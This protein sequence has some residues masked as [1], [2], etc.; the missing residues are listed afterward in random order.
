MRPTR[1][2]TC[3]VV[4]A[5]LLKRLLGLMDV[6]WISVHEVDVRFSLGKR[7]PLGRLQEILSHRST[8]YLVQPV[9]YK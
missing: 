8:M 4:L 1:R 5:A 7:V 9:P 2:L 6:R 3:A